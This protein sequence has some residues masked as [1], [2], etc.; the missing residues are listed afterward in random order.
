VEAKQGVV[1]NIAPVLTR[2][3][4]PLTVV[5]LLAFLVATLATDSAVDRDLLILVDLILVLVLGLLLYAI[6]ARDPRH[7][8]TASTV[9]RC[10]W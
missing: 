8:R 9:C 2:V 7:P 5:M 6:S 10:C 3:F 1:E 4:T